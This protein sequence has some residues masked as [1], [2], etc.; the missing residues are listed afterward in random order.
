MEYTL[1]Y[2]HTMEQPIDEMVKITTT[3]GKTI[4]VHKM[5]YHFIELLKSNDENVTDLSG[6]VNNFISFLDYWE[7]FKKS[8]KDST[9]DNKHL[10]RFNL[11]HTIKP[12][13]EYANQQEIRDGKPVL[14][15]IYRILEGTVY[16]MACGGNYPIKD[17]VIYFGDG[18]I[19]Q[20][21]K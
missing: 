13:T 18:T 11:F 8:K 14:Y 21:L 9:Y 4:E 20:T 17:C 10:T 5:V 16:S 6:I 19:I 12:K 15:P 2:N 3:N 7:D 1:I